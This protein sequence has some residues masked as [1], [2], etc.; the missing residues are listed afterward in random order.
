MDEQP[1]QFLAVVEGTFDEVEID[2]LDDISDQII[3]EDENQEESTQWVVLINEGKE[4]P[5]IQ[6]EAEQ[7]PKADRDGGDINVRQLLNELSLLEQQEIN[8]RNDDFP[9]HKPITEK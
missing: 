9:K 2:P 8:R 3:S 4:T 5:K 6:K 1:K 7:R